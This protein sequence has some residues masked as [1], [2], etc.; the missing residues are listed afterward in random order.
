MQVDFDTLDRLSAAEI[1][2]HCLWEMTFFGFTQAEI[3]A[4][5]AELER[6]VAEVEAM[7][8]EEKKE[9]LIPHERVLEELES[10]L[11]D[12]S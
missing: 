4:E 10:L 7:T 3:A 5:R 8:E 2:A 6:R 11:K 9:K 1:V 12:P